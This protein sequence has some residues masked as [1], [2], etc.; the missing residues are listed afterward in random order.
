MSD[1]PL[2]HWLLRARQRMAFAALAMVCSYIRK[3]MQENRQDENVYEMEN[4]G[5]TSLSISIQWLSNLRLG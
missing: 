4:L 3:Q 2:L 1:S 5:C